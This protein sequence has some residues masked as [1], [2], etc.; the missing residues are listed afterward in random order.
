[1]DAALARRRLPHVEPMLLD[2]AQAQPRPK[3]HANE[4]R[5]RNW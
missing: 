5:P 3:A 2:G 4:Q 1:M